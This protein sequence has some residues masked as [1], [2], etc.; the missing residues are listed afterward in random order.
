[1]LRRLRTLLL[2]RRTL[3][4]L[5]ALIALAVEIVGFNHAAW[6]TARYTPIVNPSATVHGQ[7]LEYGRHYILS[8]TTDMPTSG[9]RP[10]Q[11]IRS[12]TISISPADG[13]AI[14]VH[15]LDIDVTSNGKLNPYSSGCGFRESLMI[16]DE[17]HEFGYN[18]SHHTKLTYTYPTVMQ[19]PGGATRTICSAVPGGAYRPIHATGKVS[20]IDVTLAGPYCEGIVSSITINGRVPLRFSLLRTLLLFAALAMAACFLTRGRKTFGGLTEP[21]CTAGG[22]ARPAEPTGAQRGAWLALMFGLIALAVWAQGKT[23]ESGTGG[24]QALARSLSQGRVWIDPPDGNGMLSLAGASKPKANLSDLSDPYDYTARTF[25]NT[26][27]RFDTAYYHGTYYVYFGIVPA[28]L[29]YLPYRLAIGTDLT[30]VEASVVIDIAV[31]VSAFLL[32]DE[33]RRRLCPSLPWGLHLLMSATMAMGCACPI[34]VATSS[35][36]AIAISTGIALCTFGLALWLRADRGNPKDRGDTGKCRNTERKGT[37][38][39]R[40]SLPQG[41]PRLLVGTGM[42]GSFLM[43]LAVGCRPQLA[44]M[45][46]L[47]IPIFWHRLRRLGSDRRVLWLLVPYIPVAAGLM[48]YNAM[49]FGSPIEFGARYQLT[50]QDIAVQ[51]LEPARIPIG[52]WYFLAALPTPSPEFPFLLISSPASAYTGEFAKQVQVG[53]VLWLMPVAIVLLIPRIWKRCPRTTGLRVTALAVTLVVVAA[54]TMA[55]GLLVRYQLDFRPILC[56]AACATLMEW[57]HTAMT[58]TDAPSDAVEAQAARRYR[59]VAAI[60]LATLLMGLLMFFSQ[61]EAS[62]NLNLN[63]N[64]RFYIELREFFDILKP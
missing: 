62:G 64:T 37:P 52:L 2:P 18:A 42:A 38:N 24:Y 15:S 17:G 21:V 47:A 26:T 48:W 14:D 60:C 36:Y 59:A 29:L 20:R 63:T 31:I 28:L 45:S 7:G 46:L 43:A 11:N 50:G 39:D 19:D 13:Q 25:Y 57:M 5:C 12:L 40:G 41:E 4:A 54:D 49:R 32:M 10:E 1:M 44:L 55:G 30:D 33:L 51:Q 23:V 35:T 56:I 9:A 16:Y 27:Y 8:E 3:L 58:R 6:T 53:G 61:Y 34:I 22:T